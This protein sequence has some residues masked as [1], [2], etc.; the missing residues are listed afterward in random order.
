MPQKLHRVAPAS[1]THVDVMLGSLTAMSEEFANSLVA[2]AAQQGATVTF[3]S[4]DNFNPDQL[5]R[6]ASPYRSSSRVLVFMLSTHMA[7]RP[8]STAEAFL[9]W[10]Q[11][12][13]Q[14]MCSYSQQQKVLRESEEE[15]SVEACAPTDTA[16][17]SSLRK[18]RLTPVL[19]TAAELQPQPPT[20]FTPKPS[21]LVS[22]RHPFGGSDASL[23]EAKPDDTPLSGVQ[24][25]VFGVGNSIC[26]TYNATANYVDSRLNELG[27]L[28]VSPLGLGDASKWIDVTFTKWEKQL[29]RLVA[30]SSSSA[31]T[32]LNA[33]SELLPV[34]GANSS[35]SA[36]AKHVAGQEIALGP[37]YADALAN[38]QRVKKLS[39]TTSSARSLSF[40][41][42]LGRRRSALEPST[43]VVMPPLKQ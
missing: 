4:L 32:T 3:Q 26:R 21:V 38:Q 2:K 16:T 27:A 23:K 30:S 40:A 35:R 39:F 13:P 29:L 12:S 18:N 1:L 24:Y 28:K 37:A 20:R 5:V 36:S 15:S 31:T 22:W 42:L 14:S 43:P 19:K 34:P 25:T 10:H 8:S 11:Q 33:E 7:G 17:S 9:L 41:N 6:P